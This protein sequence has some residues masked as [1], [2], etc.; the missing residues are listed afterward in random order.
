MNGQLGG[1]GGYVLVKLT[2]SSSF[3]GVAVVVDD[4]GGA[5]LMSRCALA[6]AEKPL[7]VSNI[8]VDARRE[9]T[10]RASVSVMVFCALSGVS[11]CTFALL[12]LGN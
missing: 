5:D 2:S 8:C 12:P 4:G 1:G 6:A 7:T 11:F 9:R 10:S 3:A